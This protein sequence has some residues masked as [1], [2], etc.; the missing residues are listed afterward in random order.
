MSEPVKARAFLASM[1]EADYDFSGLVALVCQ[2]HVRT[3]QDRLQG[4]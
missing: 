3:L 1:F 4:L 2:P